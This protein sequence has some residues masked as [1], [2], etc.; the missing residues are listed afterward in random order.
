MEDITIN[1]NNG[2]EWQKVTIDVGYGIL[3]RTSFVWYKPLSWLAL[4]IIF[5][6]NLRRIVWNGI[7]GLFG[8]NFEKKEYCPY[9]HVGIVAHHHIDGWQ[10]IDA[11]SKGLLRNNIEEEVKGHYYRIVMPADM[12]YDR[13]KMNGRIMRY[14]GQKYDLSSLFIFQVIYNVFGLWLGARKKS[15]AEKAFYCSEHFG[16]S[17]KQY[18]KLWPRLNPAGVYFSEDFKPVYEDYIKEIEIIDG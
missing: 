6:I 14:L 4:A 3:K 18:F 1:I 9:N 16:W 5:F 11:K 8:L 13:K 10:S 12:S 17:W 15:K 7:I 2:K